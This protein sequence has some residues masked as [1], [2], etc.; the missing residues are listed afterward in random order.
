M[1]TKGADITSSGS[2]FHKLT[3]LN[4]KFALNC[5]RQYLFFNVYSCP[6]TADSVVLGNTPSSRCVDP[7]SKFIYFHHIAMISTVNQRW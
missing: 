7:M 4:E 2:L 5:E 1:F 6:L 3:T